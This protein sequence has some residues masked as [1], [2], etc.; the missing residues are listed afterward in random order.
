MLTSRTT[1]RL[2][3]TFKT[4]ASHWFILGTLLVSL[5]IEG[6][7]PGSSVEAIPAFAR[8]YEQ[9]CTT[10]HMGFPALNPFGE[11]F[12]NNGY[13]FPRE[14]PLEVVEKPVKLGMKAQRKLFPRKAVYPGEIPGSFPIALRLE[15]DIRARNFGD[16]RSEFR[17]P[18][19]IEVLSGGNFGEKFSFFLEMPVY[20]DG[21][22]GG[23]DR[24]FL[25]FNRLLGGQPS[26]NLKVGQFETAA[27]PFSKIRRLTM[28][29]YVVSDI[30]FG[31]IPFRLKNPQQ[32][33]EVWGI[34][35]GDKGSF[36]YG[37]GIVNG[38]ASDGGS[39]GQS[40]EGSEKDIYARFYY[41]LGGLSLDGE[42]GVVPQRGNWHDNSIRLGGFAYRG[43]A[44]SV[45]FTRVGWDVRWQRNDLVLFS[46][47]LLGIND[48]EPADLWSRRAY[49]LES[50]YY[51]LPWM[52]GALRY[53]GHRDLGMQE[54][55]KGIISHL[56]F[57]LRPNIAIRIEGAQYL[58]PQN[59][60]AFRV[61]FD[62]AF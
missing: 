48:S 61:R 56:S 21:S 41:K 35:D 37:V 9:S 50:N 16:I 52:I 4:E 7:L 40:E 27:V 29:H 26:L 53:E 39:E 36:Y 6:F 59:R 54:E 15:M 2:S 17:F 14:S 51:F 43:F 45:G 3:S 46:A 10:C 42:K 47:I 49:F 28:D 24:T 22:F 20:E 57:Y 60:F 32:G 5:I 55:G 12:R 31:E 13:R 23:L 19:E 1:A 30:I 25:Q 11:A 8:K 33:L 34:S 58:S 44:G 18:H 38:T 62:N